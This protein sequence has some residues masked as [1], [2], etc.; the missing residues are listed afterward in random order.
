MAIAQSR[1]EVPPG[2]RSGGEAVSN[3]ELADDD[4][5]FRPAS[6][7]VPP[8]RRLSPEERWQLRQQIK[9]Q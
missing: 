5:A 7:P 4:V 8:S 9:E 3:P 1:V 6:R 2:F